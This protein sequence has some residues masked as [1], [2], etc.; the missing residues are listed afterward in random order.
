MTT[1]LTI[2]RFRTRKPDPVAAP[3]PLPQTRPGGGA[4]SQAIA[5]QAGSSLAGSNPATNPQIL[6]IHG[7]AASAPRGVEAVR[8]DALLPDDPDDGFG[9]QSFLPPERNLA[10][11]PLPDNASPPEEIDAIR[12]EGLTGRQLRLARRMAQKHALPATSDFDAVRLLRHQGIDPFGR[13][14]VLELVH[15]DA[16]D[17]DDAGLPALGYAQSRAL[18]VSRGGDDTLPQTIKPVGLPST[19]VRV[20]EAHVAEV[21]R[22]QFDIVARRRRKLALMWAKLS[23]FV[24]LPTLLAGWYYYMVA[25]PMYAVTTKFVIQQATAASQFSSMFSGTAFATSQD[26]VAVQNYLQS[27]VAMER[28]DKDNGFRAHFANPTI[29]PIQRLPAHA[30]NTQTFNL[31]Q[32]YIKVS[33]DPTEGLINMEVSA[34]SPQKAVEFSKAL[35]SYAEQQV[36]QMT[37]R[38]RGDQQN[39][40]KANFDDAE[41]KLQ[42]AQTKLVTLQEKYKTLSTDVE[43]GLVT[44]QIGALNA[45]LMTDKLSLA[46]MQTNAT[47]NPARMDPVITRI[48]T[49]EDQIAQL[50]AGLTQA[51]STGPSIAS[52]QSEMVMAAAEVTTRQMMLAQSTSAMETSRIE[53]QRQTRYL[54]LAVPPVAPDTPSYPRAFENTLVVMLIFGGIY[55]MISMTIAILREQV[56]G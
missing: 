5:G 19:E 27:N 10:G 1:K 22:I 24:F 32:R 34:A 42:T 50:R 33:Y 54:E 29:D 52:M 18:T 53:A 13:S 49:M 48:K 40:A 35:V 15:G 16:D 12:R 56:S 45:Q 44:S 2:S 6:P 7:N 38:L 23:V 55:L 3:D 43:A 31:Y 14:A 28:L 8:H 36:D 26:S 9:G 41:V 4:A 17:L 37:S 51:S 46:Q 39:A 30:N 20:E 11:N 25:T 21:R 47:P